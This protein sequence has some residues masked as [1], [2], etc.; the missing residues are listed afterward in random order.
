MPIYQEVFPLLLV[1]TYTIPG[2]VCGLGIVLFLFGGIFFTL[3]TFLTCMRRLEFKDLTG[4]LCRFSKA[5]SLWQYH[6]LQ[7]FAL[8]KVQTLYLDSLKE[9]TGLCLSSP[10]LRCTLETLSREGPCLWLFFSHGSFSCIICS[11]C[12]KTVVSYVL[13]ACLVDKKNGKSGSSCPEAR[14]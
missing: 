2:P 6:S 14:V 11:Q 4:P 7:D 5:L 9:I 3:N 1:G 10:S 12:L 13:S 8:P